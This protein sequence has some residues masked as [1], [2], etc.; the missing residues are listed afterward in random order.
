MHA[1]ISFGTPFPID[2]PGPRDLSASF[3]VEVGVFA[4]VAELATHIT[5]GTIGTGKDDCQLAVRQEYTLAVGAGAGATVAFLNKTWGPQPATTIPVFY[6]TLLDACAVQGTPLISPTLTLAGRQDLK[7]TTT[8]TEVTYTGVSCISTGLVICPVSL[9][10]IVVTRTELTLST[11]VPSGEE[12]TWGAMS[13]NTV[14]SP[15]SFGTGVKELGGISGVPTSY[16]PPV[17]SETRETGG[18][19]PES[20]F[21]GG[22]GISGWST[23]DKIAL[24]V[25]V[26]VG[27]P[28]LVGLIAGIWSVFSS[29]SVF[30]YTVQF[31]NNASQTGSGDTRDTGAILRG[32]AV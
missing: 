13:I 2:I 4:H 10:K 26:G 6:T 30:Y 22:G 8:T 27:V 18:F 14:A 28:V 31:A 20:G 23:H 24:G 3:G 16:V 15:V 12:V 1:G 21:G 17:P 5:P 19:G 32:V 7:S 9:Q 25:G 11:A 29:P